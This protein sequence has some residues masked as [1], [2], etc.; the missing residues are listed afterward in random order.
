MSRISRRD[1]APRRGARALGR[2]FALAGPVL[3]GL[4]ATARIAVGDPSVAG[5]EL[6]TVAVPP[7]AATPN[8][9]ISVTPASEDGTTSGDAEPTEAGA[10]GERT[11]LA[12][13]SGSALV[14]PPRLRLPAG[15]AA[16]EPVPWYRTGIGALGLVL[17]VIGVACVALRKWSPALRS[18]G[19]GVLQIIARAPLSPKHHLALVKVGQRLVLLGIG[20]EKVTLLCEIADAQETA[21]LVAQAT[22]GTEGRF[23]EQLLAEASSFLAGEDESAAAAPL[24]GKPPKENAGALRQW[25]RRLQAMRVT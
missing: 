18:V 25:L 5:R 13:A 24:A 1:I 22:R 15:P 8:R 3:V 20:N 2:G 10:P 16:S 21:T 14:E 7:P 11:T 19:G 6:A 23:D 4:L 17:S 9:A 12:L